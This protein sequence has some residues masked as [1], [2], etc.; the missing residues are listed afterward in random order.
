MINKAP[1]LD[2]AGEGEIYMLFD[3]LGRKS[4]W[5]TDERNRRNLGERN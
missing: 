1:V 4:H 2:C 5:V 3:S